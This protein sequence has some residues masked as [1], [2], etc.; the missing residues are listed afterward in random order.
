ML[1]FSSMKRSIMFC[2]DLETVARDLTLDI[3]SNKICYCYYV[4]DNSSRVRA[5]LYGVYFTI[6]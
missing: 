3:V 5:H 1:V 6:N 4:I 2:Y